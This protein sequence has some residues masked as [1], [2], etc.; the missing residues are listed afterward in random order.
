MMGKRRAARELAL[1]LLFQMD[2][3]N[4][5]LEDVV[6]ALDDGSHNPESVAFARQLLQGTVTHRAAIDEMLERYAREWSLDRM[7]SV[8]RNVL[9][10][11]TY[12]LLFLPE[13]PPSVSVDEAVE[14]VKKY[15]T[16]ESGKFVNGILGN[17]VRH[18][19]EEQARAGV[20]R[21]EA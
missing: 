6:A 16:A 13:I 21:P 14:M 12:E 11:A 8:D 10:L 19:D 2:V 5:P 7:A 1:R 15:S 9:R 3:G 17:L 18:L 20:Q 4:A